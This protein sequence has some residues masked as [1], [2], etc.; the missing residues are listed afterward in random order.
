MFWQKTAQGLGVTFT[1]E[2]LSRSDTLEFA[3]HITYSY[4]ILVFWKDE[5]HPVYWSELLNYWHFFFLIKN[6][7]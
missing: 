5:N 3:S 6:L 1:P 4:I 7:T 2:T